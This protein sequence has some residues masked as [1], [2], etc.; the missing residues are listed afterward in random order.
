MPRLELDDGHV[1][2]REHGRGPAVV[3]IGGLGDDHSLWASQQADL[4]DGFRTIAFD[5][6][7]AGASSEA[8]DGASIAGFADDVATLIEALAGHA[9]VV[10]ASMGAAIA[11]EFAIRRPELVDGLCVIGGWSRTGPAL[12][13][14]LRFWRD[15]CGTVPHEH[16]VAETMLWRFSHTYLELHESEVDSFASAAV[17][18]G[19]PDVVSF[20]RHADACIAHDV[21]TR[22]GSITAPTWVIVGDEDRATPVADARAVAGGITGARLQ[23]LRGVGHD[24]TL[25]CPDVLNALLRRALGAE[26]AR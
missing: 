6:R 23:I 18:A 19:A 2:Y 24:V 11:L 21:A 3:F 22:L 13:R 5:N 16:L 7:G 14:L 12:S 26:A 17:S 15:A 10:G 9:H 25:E 4:A 20:R 8:P 1:V